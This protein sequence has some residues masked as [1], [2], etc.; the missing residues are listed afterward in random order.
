MSILTYNIKQKIKEHA[1]KFSNEEVCGIVFEN[2]MVLECKNIAANKRNVFQIN[3]LDYI[4]A[5][6]SGHKIAAIYH[7]HVNLNYEFSEY[8]KLNSNNL[9]IPYILYNLKID[10]FKEYY[11]GEE[12]F[13][14]F[15]GLDFRPN[16]CLWLIKELYVKKFKIAINISKDDRDI[17]DAEP[18]KIHIK[19]PLLFDKILKENSDFYLVNKNFPQ[20]YDIIAFNYFNKPFVHHLGLYLENDTFLHH[21]RNVKSRIDVYDEEYKK[22]TVSIYR[23]RKL[24]QRINLKNI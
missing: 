18:E 23:H 20:K 7:S 19:H 11:P 24:E 2:G 22:R 14:D 13:C 16:A 8:D 3:P 21:P 10:D 4:I 15:I 1:N 17:I 5:E 12:K 9:K 6:K